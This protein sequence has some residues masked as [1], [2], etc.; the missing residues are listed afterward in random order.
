M[1]IPVSSVHICTFQ[2][3]LIFEN[4]FN[5]SLLLLA[6]ELLLYSTMNSLDET[7]YMELFDD[8]GTL[9]RLTEEDKNFLER[10]VKKAAEIEREM[11]N[12]N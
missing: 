6:L 3:F 9:D 1:T 2:T 11:N 8:I 4:T 7:L 10:L 5:F 12:S